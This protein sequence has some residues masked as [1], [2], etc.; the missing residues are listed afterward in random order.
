MMDVLGADGLFLHLN[1][2]QEAVQPEGDTQ[3]MD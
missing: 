2:L 1:P 3:F